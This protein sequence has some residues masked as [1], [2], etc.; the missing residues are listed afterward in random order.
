MGLVWYLFFMLSHVSSFI[1][2]TFRSCLESVR[3]PA[4]IVGWWNQ[5]AS[6]PIFTP[7][8]RIREGWRGHCGACAYHHTALVHVLE[9]GSIRAHPQKYPRCGGKYFLHKDI[10]I[11]SII[12][13]GQAIN[14]KDSVVIPSSHQLK[15]ICK[16]FCWC[17]SKT[18]NMVKWPL[19]DDRMGISVKDLMLQVSNGNWQQFL[20]GKATHYTSITFTPTL[21]SIWQTF[22]NH[23]K[24]VKLIGVGWISYLLSKTKKSDFFSRCKVVGVDNL[25]KAKPWSAGRSSVKVYAAMFGSFGIWESDQQRQPIPSRATKQVAFRF[26]NSHL[27][28]ARCGPVA[29]LIIRRSSRW[30]LE[31]WYLATEGQHGKW[32]WGYGWIHLVMQNLSFTKG[33]AAAPVETFGVSMLMCLLFC[34]SFMSCYI[35]NRIVW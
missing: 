9:V 35:C 28:K 12:L 27:S 11:F 30:D 10:R 15:W 33:S 21:L 29:E 24:D 6:T 3:A 31:R 34:T 23:W 18:Q 19:M 25:P 32:G 1:L 16:H 8:A 26:E 22:G 7:R 20:F 2:V 17:Y 5:V 13:E 4:K 14:I